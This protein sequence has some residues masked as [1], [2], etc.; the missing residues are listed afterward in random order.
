MGETPRCILPCTDRGQ[1]INLHLHVSRGSGWVAI[2]L[3]YNLHD[4]NDSAG[5]PMRH[6]SLSARFTDAKPRL[7]LKK[8]ICLKPPP[9]KGGGGDYKPNLGLP[10]ASTS[11]SLSEAAG[12]IYQDTHQM[13]PRDTAQKWH[14]GIFRCLCAV[15][16]LKTKQSRSCAN[17]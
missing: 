1:C 7:K 3:S 9:N 12:T 10:Q 2:I 11:P 15:L 8:T 5:N 13:D 16:N 6:T 14:S 17:F 4:L